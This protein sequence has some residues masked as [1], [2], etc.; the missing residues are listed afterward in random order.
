MHRILPGLGIGG[1]YLA[2]FSDTEAPALGLAQAL[3]MSACSFL[4]P[5]RISTT[6]FGPRGICLLRSITLPS[7]IFTPTAGF[8]PLLMVQRR[9]LLSPEMAPK[10]ERGVNSSVPPTRSS[11]TPSDR[12]TDMRCLALLAVLALV[13]PAAAQQVAPL[14]LP[15]GR[16][17]CTQ[18]SAGAGRAATW[19]AVRDP[20]A[21]GGWALSETAGDATD[22]RFALCISGQTVARDLDATLRFKPVGGSHSRAAGLVLRAQSANDYYVIR[23]DALEGSVRLY[24]MA[25]GRRAQIAAKDVEVRS[26]QWHALRTILKGNNF[27]VSLDGSPVFKATDASLP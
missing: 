3:A 21:L 25:R 2:D 8:P 10:F 22:L 14:T 11:R 15:D 13:S 18:G 1:R 4:P 19:Q 7:P 9:M 6:D 20:V 24:R 16:I 5:A 26:D 23:A 12:L 17:A 27:E